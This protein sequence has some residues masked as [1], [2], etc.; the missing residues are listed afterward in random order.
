MPSTDATLRFLVCSHCLSVPKTVPK[1][2]K[3]CASLFSTDITASGSGHPYLSRDRDTG[4]RASGGR[5][6]PSPFPPGHT[7]NKAV[8]SWCANVECRGGRGGTAIVFTEYMMHT[9]YPWTGRGQRKS[10]FYKYSARCDHSWRFQTGLTKR[11]TWRSFVRSVRD[12]AGTRAC[13]C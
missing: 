6:P 12:C 13:R 5:C 11:S 8:V 2:L 4:Q 7:Q 9:T 1:T 3:R 10:V